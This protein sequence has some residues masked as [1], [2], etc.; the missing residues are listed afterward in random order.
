[1][2]HKKCNNECSIFILFILVADRDCM[3]DRA[4]ADCYKPTVLKVSFQI[5]EYQAKTLG[6]L[7]KRLRLE[8]G[9]HQKELARLL[10]VNEM[11]IVR[12][13]KNRTKL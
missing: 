4:V 1:M 2:D 11:T 12:W 3:V 9:L 13:E 8:K 7:I 10:G 6:Q 5:S